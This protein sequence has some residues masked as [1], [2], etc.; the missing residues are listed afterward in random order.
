MQGSQIKS[1]VQE[2]WFGFSLYSEGFESQ[3]CVALELQIKPEGGDLKITLPPEARSSIPL[4]Q[5]KAL[6]FRAEEGG[7][8]SILTLH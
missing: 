7:L 5:I 3:L 2:N 1:L 8:T 4:R 6:Q